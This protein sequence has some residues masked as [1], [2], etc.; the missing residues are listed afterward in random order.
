M[1][2]G[3]G[4]STPKTHDHD[5]HATAVPYARSLTMGTLQRRHAGSWPRRAPPSLGVAAAANRR[6]NVQPRSTGRGA[7]PTL[8][9]VRNPPRFE[10][11]TPRAA[12]AT[13]RLT[14]SPAEEA[15]RCGFASDPLQRRVRAGEILLTLSTGRVRLRVPPFIGAAVVLVFHRRGELPPERPRT[16]RGRRYEGPGEPDKGDGMWWPR[17][18]SRLSVTVAVSVSDGVENL[19]AAVPYVGSTAGLALAR[20]H[21]TAMTC[22]GYGVG[23]CCLPKYGSWSACSRSWGGLLP[24]RAGRRTAGGQRRTGGHAE[25]TVRGLASLL[26][27]R[28]SSGSAR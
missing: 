23:I 14:H 22:A 4:R 13:D 11:T 10:A 9:V 3:P 7:G 12:P 24:R 1:R 19:G 21:A 18:A 25:G 16:L 28:F 27:C 6:D 5:V 15:S 20:R 8:A 17:A 2:F 26:L